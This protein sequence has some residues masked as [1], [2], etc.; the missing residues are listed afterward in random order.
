M[1]RAMLIIL[2]IGAIVL[3]FW[4]GWLGFTA[5]KLPQDKTQIGI[6]VDR[7]EAKK[8]VDAWERKATDAWRDV[9]G[10]RSSDGSAGNLVPEMS[11][12]ELATG[13]ATR[14][15]VTRAGD[16]LKQ[17]QLKLSSTPDSNLVVTGGAFAA[18]QKDT[19]IT[20]EAPAGATGGRIYLGLDGQQ[21]AAITVD[22]VQ[23]VSVDI[24]SHNPSIRF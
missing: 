7:G 14:I 2:V 3:A 17:A 19:T 22:V 12:I 4:F 16:D 23:A 24:P 13:T 5:T 10:K 11:R 21:E 18:G 6:T 20:I 9:T 8:D 15:K 1:L